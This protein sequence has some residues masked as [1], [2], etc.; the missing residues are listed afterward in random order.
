MDAF[1][2]ANG[3]TPEFPHSVS[4]AHEGVQKVVLKLPS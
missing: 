4:Q 2:S 3:K 1:Y